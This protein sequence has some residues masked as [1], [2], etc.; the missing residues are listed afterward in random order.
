MC[1]VACDD[2][3]TFVQQILACPTCLSSLQASGD[4][5]VGECLFCANCGAIYPVRSGVPQL[6]DLRVLLRL[7]QELLAAWHITQQ[8]AAALYQELD[9]GSCSLSTREDV[10]IFRQFMHLRDKAVLDIGSGSVLLPGYVEATNF[11]HYVGIDPL[12][13][14]S[15]PDFPFLVSLGEMLAF[16]DN[17]FDVVILATSL[18]HMLDVDKTL[19][20]VCRVLK[21]EGKVYFWG[22]YYATPSVVDQLLSPQLF[23]RPSPG[24]PQALADAVGAYLQHYTTYVAALQRIDAHVDVYEPLLVDRY[25]FRHFTEESLVAAFARV[26]L[27]RADESS[28]TAQTGVKSQCICFARMSHSYL[29]YHNFAAFQRELRAFQQEQSAGQQQ[30]TVLLQ[31]IEELQHQMA[32][33]QQLQSPNGQQEHSVALQLQETQKSVQEIGRQVQATLQQLQESLRAAH[34]LGVLSIRVLKGIDLIL[35]VVLWPP[36]FAKRFLSGAIRAARRARKLVVVAGKCISA[37]VRGKDRQKTRGRNVLMLTISQIDIDPRVNKVAA[38]L[39]DN[40]YSVDILCYQNT[41]GV[42]TVLEEVVRPGVRYVRVPREGGWQG[43]RFLFQLLYQEEFRQAA[44][45]RSYDYVHANDLTT[46]LVGWILARAQGVP[47]IYDAHEMWSENVTCKGQEWVPMP[48]LT[49][50]I[51]QHYEGFLFR[52][53]DLCTT[54]SPSICQEFQRRYTLPQ[55][56][57]LLANYP[58]L[59]LVR[60]PPRE[61][62]STRELCG[63]ADHHFITLYM[64]GVNP[65][66]NIE[67]VITAHQ[68]L[69]KDCVFVIRGPGIEYYGPQYQTLAKYYGLEQRVFCLP[70]VAMDEVIAGAAGADCGIVMLQNICKNFY[71]FYPNKFFE[72]MLAGLPVAVSNFPDVAAHVQREHCGVVF[73]PESPHSIAE[74]LLW[75]YEHPEEARAMGCRGQ[76]GVLR[77]YNWEGV[78]TPLVEAYQKL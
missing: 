16:R 8:R 61:L 64:G 71:W 45:R 4:E 77:E 17:S 6:I 59:R 78:T 27:W 51:L 22:G 5:R 24:A 9:P 42:A 29:L 67:N 37:I 70:P 62:P 52:Y 2:S 48:P 44:L 56:P 69:P 58:E 47:L 34:D 46:L 75:L 1:A 49:R 35:R 3:K 53:V 74:A 13:A 38:T 32:E 66:R 28:I 12:P 73:D 7:P 26:G 76:A 43:T 19:S 23:Q 18:D 31:R 33:V 63:L 54:V 50:R 10:Q 40:G 14:L 41:M 21:P 15:P 36:R 25:H 20:E 30:Q 72:Y 39:A 68:Y 11:R 57:Y 60:Q 65:L 55:P